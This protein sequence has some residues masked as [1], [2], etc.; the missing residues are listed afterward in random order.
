MIRRAPISLRLGITTCERPECHQQ[1]CM[2]QRLLKK[3]YASIETPTIGTKVEMS[4]S[5]KQKSSSFFVSA[6]AT[7]SSRW[8]SVAASLFWLSMVTGCGAAYTWVKPGADPGEKD[9]QLA[10]C[11]LEAEKQSAALQ[12]SKEVRE[13]RVPHWTEL[14]MRS[15]GWQKTEAQ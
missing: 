12:D 8:S 2:A 9:Q 14:C 10:A 7:P 3:R 15:N 4:M 13:A 5:C 11:Q 6:K 1:N